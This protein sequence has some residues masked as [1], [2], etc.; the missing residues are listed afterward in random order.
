MLV[1]LHDEDNGSG[2][3]N[4]HGGGVLELDGAFHGGVQIGEVLALPSHK[5]GDTGVEVP[6]VDLL[7]TRAAGVSSRLI[8][9][10]KSRRGWC[11]GK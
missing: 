11:R 6:S 1:G 8:E 7:I 5:V 9:V 2:T 10:E 3:L 4:L